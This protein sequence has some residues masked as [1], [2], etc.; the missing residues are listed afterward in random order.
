M[1]LV[2]TVGHK[3]WSIGPRREFYSRPD[4]HCGS[5]FTPSASRLPYLG[6]F[7]PYLG[8]LGSSGCVSPSTRPLHLTRSRQLPSAAIRIPYTVLCCS[9][10]K[11][12]GQLANTNC[13]PTSGRQAPP[14]RQ[15]FNPSTRQ[16][17]AFRIGSRF[18]IPWSNMDIGSGRGRAHRTQPSIYLRILMLWRYGHHDT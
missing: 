16:P 7:L 5:R 12:D 2:W 18:I 6:S 3:I 10:M 9:S 11:L 14:A 1:R 8:S 17:D 4:E 13:Q 15:P